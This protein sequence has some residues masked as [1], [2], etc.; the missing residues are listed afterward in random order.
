MFPYLNKYIA[1]VN[2]GEGPPKFYWYYAVS[3]VFGFILASFFNLS[4]FTGLVEQF[5]GATVAASA[6]II[7]SVLVAYGTNSLVNDIMK[8]GA[9]TKAGAEAT[10]PSVKAVDSG[11]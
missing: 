8:T 11:T 9:T 2:T 7:N 10:P 1:A 4:L 3:A 5:A 6:I